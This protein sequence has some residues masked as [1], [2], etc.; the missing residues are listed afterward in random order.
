M[1]LTWKI[2]TKTNIL[3]KKLGENRAIHGDENVKELFSG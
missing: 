2:K 3:E 1:S